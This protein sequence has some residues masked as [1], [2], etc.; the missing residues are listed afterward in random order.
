MNLESLLKRALITILGFSCILMSGPNAVSSDRLLEETKSFITDKAIKKAST[1]E[2]D[3]SAEVFTLGFNDYQDN[4][5]KYLNVVGLNVD[6]KASINAEG[7]DPNYVAPSYADIIFDYQT[8]MEASLTDDQLTRYTDF[9]KQNYDFDRYIVLNET[10]Y[11]NLYA[12]PR[13]EHKIMNAIGDSAALDQLRSLLLDGGMVINA[14]TAFIASVKGLITAVETALIPFFGKIL[15]AMLAT[16]A[17]IAITSLVVIYWDQ[18]CAML[19]AIQSWF[20]EQF[21]AIKDLITSFFSNVSSTADKSTVAGTAV[22]GDKT[23]EFKQVYSNDVA[24]QVELVKKARWTND[25]YL[26]QYV[27]KN[28]FQV[29]MEPVDFDFCVVAGT[30]KTGFSSYTWYQNKARQLILQAGNKCTTPKPEIDGYD[31]NFPGKISFKHFHNCKIS[32]AE[33]VRVSATEDPIL[34]RTH[35]FFGQMYYY[36]DANSE[37]IV[38]P[39]SPNPKR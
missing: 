9:Q 2:S 17:L 32:G 39:N 23:L 29:C 6:E 27:G 10:K 26:M 3:D 1:S 38:H 35:S 12:P 24:T 21:A 14:V 7:Y 34:H 4:F 16:G 33:I 8:N 11:E 36:P 5:D 15:C 28:S 31:A 18:V 20:E 13:Y 22:I 25:I 30:H 19:E 37:A